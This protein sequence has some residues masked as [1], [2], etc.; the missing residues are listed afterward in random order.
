M[1]KR[2]NVLTPPMRIVKL[3]KTPGSFPKRKDSLMPSPARA[4]AVLQDAG[5]KASATLSA[6]PDLSF[7]EEDTVLKVSNKQGKSAYQ[8]HSMNR[9]QQSSF[10]EDF[11]S[12]NL[13]D[14]QRI[15]VDEEE[16]RSSE[17]DQHKQES[18]NEEN[19]RVITNSDDANDPR[20]VRLHFPLAF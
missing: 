14:L 7:V 18:P 12:E 17:D 10:K 3:Q 20:L 11:E 1:S 6:S 2:P 19:S 16:D 8:H 4:T 13:P 15:A 9:K 5:S